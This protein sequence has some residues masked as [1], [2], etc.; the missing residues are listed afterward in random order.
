MNES[1][2]SQR[3]RDYSLLAGCLVGTASAAQAQVKCF[4]IIPDVEIGGKIPSSFP[5]DYFWN[6]DLNNDG[7]DDFKLSVSVYGVNP[8][9]GFDFVE[10]VAAATNPI[11]NA[12][13]TYSINYVP[14]AL[15]MN[16]GNK[17]PLGNIFYGI[18]FAFLAYKI[19]NISA[20]KWNNE[21]DRHIGVRFLSN[22]GIHY[23]WVR[24]DVNTKGTIPNI[25]VK[26]YAYDLTPQ[27][28]I[29]VCDSG[30]A[31]AVYVGQFDEE[32][33]PSHS[34][35]AVSPNPTH[36]NTLLSIPVE[37]GQDVLVTLTNPQ[38]AVLHQM[39]A[40]TGKPIRIDI[41]EF[42]EGMY[43]LHVASSQFAQSVKIVKH[44]QAF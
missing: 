29:Y 14:W 6:L 35:L 15:K 36:S 10:Q 5:F 24:L 43:L 33:H 16:C 22:A 2:L 42:A 1:R 9:G 13:A 7:S 34:S 32:L 30:G 3:L 25:V 39:R 12:V 4:D 27:Q 18:S 8:T 23:G 19:G 21:I 37:A 28:H 26:E 20:V 17:V 31:C 11:Y 38:G 41:S 44:Q 40:S